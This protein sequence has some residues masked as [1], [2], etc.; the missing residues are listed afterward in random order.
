MKTIKLASIVALTLFLS[1]S[2]YAKSRPI[3]FHPRWEQSFKSTIIGE[4]LPFEAFIEDSN[5]TLQLYF[6]DNVEGLTIQIM[7]SKGV[8]IHNNTF[9][10]S[11]NETKTISLNETEK[12]EY[13]IIVTDDSKYAYAKIEL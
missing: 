2:A 10:A 8:E 7:D 11:L 12:G 9:N 6:K 13:T 1:I 4:S 5:N 3:K